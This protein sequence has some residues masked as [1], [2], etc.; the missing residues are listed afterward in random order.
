MHSSLAI[1]EAGLPMGLAAVTF[2]TR[3]EFKGTNALKRDW[4]EGMVDFIFITMNESL[5]E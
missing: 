5:N 3:K 4:V 1:T 2:W